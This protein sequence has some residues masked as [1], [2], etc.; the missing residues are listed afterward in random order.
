VA[1]IDDITEHRRLE[2]VRRDFVANI[3][4]ELK[5][6]VG[7][8]GL[9]AETLLGEDDPEVAARLAGR[10]QSE[11]LW[12]GRTIDDL[13]ELSRIETSSVQQPAQVSVAGVIGEAVSRIN[14]AAEHAGISIDTTG[15]DPA[16]EVRGD[17]RQLTSAI[18]NLL[19]NAV[20]YSD[21]GSTV[22]VGAR[23]AD[24][25]LLSISVSD[26]GI[27][28]P[29]RD[30]ERVFERFYRVDQGRSRETGGTG[31][32]L[33]I[34][35]HVAANHR[36]TVEVASRLGEGSTFTLRLPVSHFPEPTPHTETELVR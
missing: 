2:A 17:A 12:V 10:I 18:S 25:G 13:L 35:R 21:P 32:G 31:L 33:A 19:D 15:V 29:A 34:V 1:L 5:T 28:I 9:L 26:H 8:I 4:H 27:G 3:S 7:A 22:E 14:P 20:K 16:V 11:S 36:G 30:I 23:V 6:P 24:D